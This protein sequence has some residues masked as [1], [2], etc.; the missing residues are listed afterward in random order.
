MIVILLLL[1]TIKNSQKRRIP[2]LSFHN[3]TE[4]NVGKL[5][6]FWYWARYFVL[7]TAAEQTYFYEKTCFSPIKKSAGE[8]CS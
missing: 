8:R 5:G 4:K 6:V 3:E 2:L 7:G 1:I